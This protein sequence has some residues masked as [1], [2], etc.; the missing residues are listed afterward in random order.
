M[1]YWRGRHPGTCSAHK[2]GSHRAYA[3]SL[4]SSPN[5]V[6]KPLRIPGESHDRIMSCW[7]SCQQ[8]QQQANT[9]IASVKAKRERDGLPSAMPFYLGC[10][11]K[12][13]PTFGL[14]TPIKAIM[15]ALQVSQPT[16]VILIY[17]KLTLK[18]TITG[19]T[20]TNFNNNKTYMYTNW[21]S[22]KLKTFILQ[23]KNIKE[24]RSRSNINLKS[25]HL[26]E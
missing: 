26:G 6:P 2:A 9:S 23:K 18:P 22:L 25:Q 13:P 5:L 15:T 19:M 12:V 16:L 20:K 3:R 14:S 7:L 11:Q 17:Y 10:Y 21:A 24:V 1:S 8:H 4:S